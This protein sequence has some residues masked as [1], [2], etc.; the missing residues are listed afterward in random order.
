MQGAEDRECR[1][2]ARRPRHSLVP[3]KAGQV[4]RLIALK[5]KHRVQRRR[6][7]PP[8][9]ALPLREFYIISTSLRDVLKEDREEFVEFIDSK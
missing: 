3:R 8:D 2:P 7:P 4:D 5:E 6:S 1:G 9:G